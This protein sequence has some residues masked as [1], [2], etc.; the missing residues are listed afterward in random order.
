M[1]V[2]AEHFHSVAIGSFDRTIA[3]PA[4]RRFGSGWQN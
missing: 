4:R 1:S 2:I 3:S